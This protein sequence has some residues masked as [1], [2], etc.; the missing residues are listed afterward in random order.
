MADTFAHQVGGHAASI[1]L[2]PTGSS[3]VMKPASETELNF[4]QQLGPELDDL[5][6]GN[7][8]GE[9]TPAYYGTLTLQGR[10]GQDGQV[11]KEANTKDEVPKVSITIHPGLPLRRIH[12]IAR[13]QGGLST[14]SAP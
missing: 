13:R 6:P 8:I 3:T 7:F 14:K 2:S 10:M 5:A 4:Y 12:L 1:T 9:W 11:D